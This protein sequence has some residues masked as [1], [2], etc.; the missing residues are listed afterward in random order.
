MNSRT[1][2]HEGDGQHDR[3]PLTGHHDARMA[4]KRARLSPEQVLR[5]E[6]AA[7]HQRARTISVLLSRL[8]SWIERSSRNALRGRIEGYLGRATDA[9]DLERRMRNIERPERIRIYG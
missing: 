4:T 7:R 8:A 3:H 5:I 6:L 2:H 1:P 9:A